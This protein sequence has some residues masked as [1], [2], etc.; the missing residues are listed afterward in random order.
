MRYQ[1]KFRRPKIIRKFNPYH[2]PAGSSSGGQFTSGSGQ[3]GGGG[4]FVRGS[5]A[6]AKPPKG[7]HTL[8][9]PLHK[10]FRVFE[11]VKT[12]ES[13]LSRMTQEA[14]LRR[15]SREIS[16][17]H[18][19]TVPED[20]GAARSALD[21]SE[22]MSTI[23][24]ENSQEAEKLGTSE[25]HQAAAAAHVQA[26]HDATSA[27]KKLTD[28]IN[29]NLGQQGLSNDRKRAVVAGLRDL[30]HQHSLMA[31]YHRE[32]ARSGGPAKQPAFQD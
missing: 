20:F 16:T 32:Q 4:S 27:A 7:I 26:A 29:Q 21:Q 8:R 18:A 6:A 3:S 10:P 14:E 28:T 12:P 1:V 15:M 24:N 19:M 17:I 25:D 13:P 30:A 22:K 31:V 11:V 9:G 23:A 2:E 5:G